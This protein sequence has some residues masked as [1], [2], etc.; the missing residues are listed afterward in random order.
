MGRQPVYLP[1]GL[2]SR[3]LGCRLGRE[4]KH[5]FLTGAIAFFAFLL[6]RPAA[7]ADLGTMPLKAWPAPAAPDWTGF[8]LGGHF[9]YATGTS[10]WAATQEGGAAALN[11]SL[12]LFN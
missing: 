6:V 2:D 12:D 11:G 3:V 1:T 9:G 7:A 8:Y 10:N 5:A 4:M